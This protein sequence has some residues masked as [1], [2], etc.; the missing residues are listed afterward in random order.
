MIM[1]NIIKDHWPIVLTPKNIPVSAI[2]IYDADGVECRYV[3]EVNR[4]TGECKKCILN[5]FNIAFATSEG[6]LAVETVMLK[7]PIIITHNS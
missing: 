3:L 4:I 1:K 5:E 6:E 2:K 7:I